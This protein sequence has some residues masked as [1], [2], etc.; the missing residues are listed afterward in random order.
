MQVFIS[1]VNEQLY[2]EEVS[3]HRHDCHDPPHAAGVGFHDDKSPPRR[4]AGVARSAHWRTTHVQVGFIGCATRRRRSPWVV[5]SDLWNNSR[6]KNCQRRDWHGGDYYPEQGI[7]AL[8]ALRAAMIALSDEVRSRSVQ[9]W[10]RL[11]VP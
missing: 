6:G 7:H 11:L 5:G 9:N 2:W 10:R 8:A 4:L 3:P 1:L